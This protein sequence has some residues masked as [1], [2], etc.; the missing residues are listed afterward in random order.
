[1]VA[2]GSIKRGYTLIRD[3]VVLFAVV[4]ASI[5]IVMLNLV[6]YVKER[7]LYSDQCV[8]VDG[9]ASSERGRD[10][11][12]SNLQPDTAT[13][14]KDGIMIAGGANNK[15]VTKTSEKRGTA[16]NA[17]TQDVNRNV[18]TVILADGD[19]LY[20]VLIK[21][22]IQNASSHLIAKA[23]D[24]VYK[25]S[26]L[27]VGQSVNVVILASKHG[28]Y[29]GEV[30][31]RVGSV[32][33]EICNKLIQ[34]RLDE[35]QRSY[36]AQVK[37]KQEDVYS[38]HSVNDA[39][40]LV[41]EGIGTN[42]TAKNVSNAINKRVANINGNI[43]SGVV[44]GNFSNAAKSAGVPHSILT[45]Y[46]R[47]FSYSVDFQRDI[48]NGSEFKILYDATANKPKILYASLTEKGKAL[49]IYRYDFEGGAFDYFH[50]DG[51][52]I[53]KALLKTPVKSARISSGYGV[54][55]H[56]ILGYS[57]AHKGLDYKAPHGAPVLAAGD[58]VIESVKYQG[59]FGKHVKIQHNAK[60][61]TLYAHL[62]RFAKSM[63]A[64][65]KIKQGD[66]VGYVGNTGLSTGSHL[67]FELHE[68]GNPINPTKSVL[69]NAGPALAAHQLVAF[70]Q[71]QCKVD[72]I[73]SGGQDQ[74]SYVVAY[75]TNSPF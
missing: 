1:M 29:G 65:A 4:L 12:L 61:A 20:S 25:L 39:S 36:V 48:K 18:T 50:K 41:I 13:K 33:L 60:Y 44:R 70:K 8:A 22:G 38:K 62:D 37:T 51:T 30:R 43:V 17:A 57:R 15:S 7:A 31:P 23:V 63:Q 11:R 73:V 56:P 34:I 19:T 59:H 2:I 27:K 10:I 3:S 74:E 16:K 32:N 58:G 26:Q 64:G 14:G 28:A 45:E 35:K 40:A 52:N 72:N 9:G 54:R 69:L 75:N 67:H 71:R 49:E 46:I 66:L 6:L 68:N 53:R 55:Y 21:A 24:K 5:F 47:L 42:N